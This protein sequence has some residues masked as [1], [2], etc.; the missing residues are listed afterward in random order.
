MKT[1]T[2]W[3][4]IP[5]KKSV[6][7]GLNDV[8]YAI[9]QLEYMGKVESET[10]WTQKNTYIKVEVLDELDYVMFRLKDAMKHSS[11]KILSGKPASIKR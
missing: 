2:I 7:Y 10:F 3:L 11:V 1:K 5:N 9:S 4:G 6:D 8:E